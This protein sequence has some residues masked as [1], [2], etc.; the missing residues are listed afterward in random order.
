MYSPV[1]LIRGERERQ[2]TTKKRR[3]PVVWTVVDVEVTA[4]ASVGVE[5]ETREVAPEVDEDCSTAADGELLV[6]DVATTSAA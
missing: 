5:E 4:E 1:V 3:Y 2:K 6:E